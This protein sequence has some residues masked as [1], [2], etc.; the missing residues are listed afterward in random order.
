MLL[1]SRLEREFGIKVSFKAFYEVPTVSGV[2]EHAKPVVDH[3]VPTRR[4]ASEETARP[5][6]WPA[7]P[8]QE[9]LWVHSAHQPSS[10]YN[11]RLDLKIQ[12]TI[13][14]KRL[15]AAIER[16]IFNRT[17]FNTRFTWH[18]DRLYQE[19]RNDQSLDLQI[20]DVSSWPFPEQTQ[21]I[22]ERR[23]ALWGFIFDP[24]TGPL[25]AMEVVVTQEGTHLICSVHH[26]AVDGTSARSFVNAIEWEYHR[27]AGSGA[28]Q[29]PSVSTFREYGEWRAH[30]AH[31]APYPTSYKEFWRQHLQSTDLAPR[32][33]TAHIE[34]I[35]SATGG[36]HTVQT[37]LTESL[38]KLRDS[39]RALGCT[40][41]T[42]LFAA[43]AALIYKYSGVADFTVGVPTTVHR[44]PQFEAVIGN[45]INTLPV[46]VVVLDD[47]SFQAL[48]V[49][50]RGELG[51]VFDHSLPLQEIVAVVPSRP[52][53]AH[54]LFQYTLNYFEAEDGRKAS[55]IPNPR[56]DLDE[57]SDS[58]FDVALSITRKNDQ[59]K[60]VVTS[61]ANRLSE[62]AT[63]RLIEDY[64]TLLSTM[65]DASDA[66]IASVPL[67]SPAEE[68]L[69]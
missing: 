17:V 31:H 18:G 42:V 54:P 32:L 69:V 13:D 29:N 20:Y 41:F 62:Q 9:S 51:N 4:E 23:H 21:F 6:R 61:A 55:D 33:T 35:P 63:Q 11:V 8:E 30:M 44:P 12:E 38:P 60:L 58:E 34:D 2:L 59:L 45:F 52:M 26:M 57:D 67:I 46:R 37:I 40:P 24:A 43:Y 10:T 7:T 25:H 56:W 47:D 15:S 28:V 5:S 22:E 66:I 16:V 1:L 27:M 53:D 14:A 65:L 48:A 3:A 36:R 64:Q 68:A 49:R 19:D 50:L 39:S